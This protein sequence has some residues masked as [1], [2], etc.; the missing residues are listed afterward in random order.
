MV[1]TN[2]PAQSGMTNH[3]CAESADIRGVSGGWERGQE[4]HRKNQ[5]QTSWAIKEF[6]KFLQRCPRRCARPRRPCHF[7][8]R[9]RRFTLWEGGGMD[10]CSVQ[11]RERHC[12]IIAHM[13]G[14]GRN[15]MWQGRPALALV[16]RLR[17]RCYIIRACGREGS[18]NTRCW[19][20][21]AAVRRRTNATTYTRGFI[22]SN[23]RVNNI[24]VMRHGN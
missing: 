24:Y 2:A 15:T 20:N 10:L 14:S 4:V 19:Q 18:C 8:H 16:V 13:R 7:V 3:L 5:M 11:G 1:K 23:Y 22:N 12:Y 21:E 17:W 9:V 6:G